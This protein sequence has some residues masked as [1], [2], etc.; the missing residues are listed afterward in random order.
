MEQEADDSKQMFFAQ[1][2]GQVEQKTIESK[3]MGEI[4]ENNWAEGWHYSHM[5]DTNAAIDWQ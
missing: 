2:G 4:K 5:E 3:S 1:R